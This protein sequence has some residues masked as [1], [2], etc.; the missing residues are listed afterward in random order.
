MS[1]VQAT[2]FRILCVG[3]D[4]RLLATRQ[5]LLVLQGY[6]C[7]TASPA[8]IEEKLS[9]GRFDLVILSVMLSEEDKGQIRTK[10]PAGTMV[11]SLTSLVMPEELLRIVDEA[12]MQRTLAASRLQR[13][14]AH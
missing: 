9:P 13:D 4:E 8:D 12:L 10:T 11:V 14:G 3:I 5:A 7:L 2:R 6:D 1:N